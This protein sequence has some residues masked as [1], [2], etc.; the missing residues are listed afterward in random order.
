MITHAVPEHLAV[1]RVYRLWGSQSRSRGV[2]V[3]ADDS[4]EAVVSLQVA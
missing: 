3:F 1:L 4:A 2:A